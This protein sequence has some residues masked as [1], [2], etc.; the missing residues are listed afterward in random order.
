IQF[1]NCNRV[2]LDH[3]S[4]SWACDETVDIYGS[5]DVTIQ[6]STI[7]ESATTGHPKGRHN[8]GLINGPRGGRLTLHHNLFAHHSRRCPA[9]AV[10][11]ADVRNNVV[12]NFRDAFL[13]DNEPDDGGYN[14]IGNYYKAGPS[15]AEI[16]PFCFRKQVPYY[17]R[18]NF[19]D[20]V[21]L[22]RDPWA[23]ADKAPGLKRYA[24][25]GRMAQAEFAV[26]PVATHPPE[27][28][29]RLVLERAGCFPRDAVTVRTVR[30]VET[31]TGSW[32][33]R[34]PEDL[35]DGLTPAAPPADTD[36]DGMSDAWEETNGLDPSDATDGAKLTPSGYTAVEEYLNSLADALV[37]AAP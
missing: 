22:I 1:G 12:Y 8:F 24:A 15:S 17:P 23:E 36:G 21:G 19:I 34:D 13:H 20:G 33:R 10:G 31:G 32:G 30:E 11:P 18:D 28:A 27:E 35:M 2:I 4:C 37:S 9:V 5:R 26:P 16:F 25:F 3:V 7:E 29:Y 14:I 6:W